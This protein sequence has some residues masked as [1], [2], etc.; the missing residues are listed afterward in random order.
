MF[1]IFLSGDGGYF[2]VRYV[3]LLL[4]RIRYSQRGSD[5]HL[6]SRADSREFRSRLNTAAKL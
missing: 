6:A 3:P 5:L 2:S 4:A 1:T